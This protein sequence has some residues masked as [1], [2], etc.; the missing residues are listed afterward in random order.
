MRFLARGV[1]GR[2]NTGGDSVRTR[3]ANPKDAFDN[4]NWVGARL[5]RIDAD[6]GDTLS[7]FDIVGRTLS[8]LA[9]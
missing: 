4:G 2:R 8:H 3:S 9:N 1:H 6:E 5:H 7:E